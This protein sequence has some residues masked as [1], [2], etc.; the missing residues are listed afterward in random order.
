M[1]RFIALAALMV[2]ST[3]AQAGDTYSFDIGGRTIR[4]EKPRDCDD[5]SCV[6]VSIPGVY[7]SRPK[8]AKR[9]RAEQ[10]DAGDDLRDGRK[11]AQQSRK[12]LAQPE[13]K[14][15][16]AGVDPKE[17]TSTAPKVAAPPPHV[18]AATT[19]DP[20][21]AAPATTANRA[22]EP[23]AA[24]PAASAESPQTQPPAP[25]VA[26]VPP[27]VPAQ[28]QTAPVVDKPSP[29]GVWLT[30][31]REG[32]IRIEQCGPHLCGY[33]VDAR[34][35]QNGEKILINMKPGGDNKW[36]GRIYDPKSGSR[37]DSTIALN[38]SDRLKVRGCAFGGM[39]CGG[40]VWSRVE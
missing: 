38:G 20:A 30:E 40:Q 6:S 15:T 21:T 9:S 33:S 11:P 7:E 10:E 32:K 13:P 1:K 17:P 37:Y 16:A 18:P 36:S 24:A 25:V 26:A 2:T 34:S 31:E 3:V 29:L 27:S 8:R 14:D 19:S 39:F 23:P 22:P 4:I 35:N 5:A 12:P 28:N